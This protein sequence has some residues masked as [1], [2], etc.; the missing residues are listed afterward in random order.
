MDLAFPSLF[1]IFALIMMELLKRWTLPIAMIAGIVGYFVYTSIPALN[2][3]HAWVNDFI[4]VVQPLLLF[5]M[6][7]LTFCKVRPS[8]LRLSPWQGWLLLF[9]SSLFLALCLVVIAMPQESHMRVVVEGAMLCFI[10]PTATAAAVATRKL[11]GNAG[12]LMMYTI[13]INLVVATLVPA[14]L[15]FIHPSPDAT[16]HDTGFWTA[17][18]LIISRVFPLLLGP[19]LLSIVLRAIAPE[20]TEWLSQKRDLPFYLWAVSLSLAIAVSVKSIV[21]TQLPWTYQMGIALTSL[22]ACFIQFYLGRRVGMK[23]KDTISAAQACG[24]KNTVF[25]IWLG[26]TFMTPVTS[27]AGGFYSIWHNLWNSYQLRKVEKGS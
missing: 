20:I 27:I 2:P 25:I 10:C 5:A 19:F 14:M 16:L 18:F 6:L 24:Q 9:Q 8:D 13:L 23:Y 15:P 22:L 21:H 4:A 1:S 17:F 26:Y 3:T 7:F 12:T 11:G